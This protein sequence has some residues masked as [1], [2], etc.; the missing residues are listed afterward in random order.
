MF[1]F[2][3]HHKGKDMHGQFKDFAI[4]I[5]W[6]VKSDFKFSTKLVELQ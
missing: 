3:G 1:C 6:V 5:I 4:L 2:S